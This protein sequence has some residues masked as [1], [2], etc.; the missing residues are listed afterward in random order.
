MRI[1]YLIGILEYRRFGIVY[2][3]LRGGEAGGSK[4]D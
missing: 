3:V 4:G 2:C 1:E